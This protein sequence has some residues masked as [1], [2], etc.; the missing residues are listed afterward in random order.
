[1]HCYYSSLNANG[2]KRWVIKINGKH[3]QKNTKHI[4]RVGAKRVTDDRETK[5]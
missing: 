1:M 5:C 4:I 2:V 3:N